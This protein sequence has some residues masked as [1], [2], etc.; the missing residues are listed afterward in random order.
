MVE[1]ISQRSGGGPTPGYIL[2]QAGWGFEQ[3]IE[4][5]MLLLTAVFQSKPFC[6]FFP[7]RSYRGI[8]AQHVLS[9]NREMESFI[10]SSCVDIIL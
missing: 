6:D 5:K 2:G 1:Q 10:H 9:E 8:L 7:F 4:L 3:L